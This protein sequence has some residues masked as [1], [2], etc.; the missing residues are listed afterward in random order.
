MPVYR[1]DTLTW[2]GGK[3]EARTAI[4]AYGEKRQYRY[5]DVGHKLAFPSEAVT[6]RGHVPVAVV[7]CA[8]YAVP[9]MEEAEAVVALTFALEQNR[10]PRGAA[11][12]QAIALV[13]EHGFVDHGPEHR[14][15]L[16]DSIIAL[17]R[18]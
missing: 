9:T 16:I 11:V 13:A 14:Q 15:L 17:A 5:A 6:K 2:V 7:M 8:T 4:G 12:I 1:G 18:D 10:V 3:G